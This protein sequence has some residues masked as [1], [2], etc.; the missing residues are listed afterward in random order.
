M[1]GNED[2]S[3]RQHEYEMDFMGAWCL[4]FEHGVELSAMN[5]VCEND[6]S[7]HVL[8]GYTEPYNI[9]DIHGCMH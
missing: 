3:I 4:S 2:G 7:V 1:L 6:T 5:G 9:I 8:G